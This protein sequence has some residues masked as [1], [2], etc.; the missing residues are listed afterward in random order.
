MPTRY[1]FYVIILIVVFLVIW[2]GKE[3]FTQPGVNDLELEFEEMAFYRNENN[4]GPVIRVYSVYAADTLWNILE[5]YGAFM[6]HTKY[7][8]TK[9]FFF[10]SKENS[11]KTT[12]PEEPYFDEKYYKHCIGKYEKSSMGDEKFVKFPF[13]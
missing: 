10:D 6:P 5:E 13:R 4:T 12:F 9:V 1:L 11:P 3:S 2:I 8:N 7:G